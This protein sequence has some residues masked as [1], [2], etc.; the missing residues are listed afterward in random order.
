MYLGPNKFN[1]ASLIFSGPE[2]IQEEAIMVTTCLSFLPLL[3][4]NQGAHYETDCIA[5]CIV[6]IDICGKQ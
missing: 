5:L 3:K 2:H 6:F 4:E 1:Q